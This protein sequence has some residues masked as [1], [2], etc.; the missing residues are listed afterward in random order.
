MGESAAAREQID[1]SLPGV[2]RTIG[3]RHLIRQTYEELERIFLSIGFT[4]VEAPDGTE[5]LAAFEKTPDEFGM[6][7]TDVMMPK[8]GG[9][10]LAMKV[11]ELRPDLPVVFMSGFL[12][13]PE[14]L[15]M[16]NDRRVR[17]LS[18]PFDIDALVTTIKSE[19]GGVEADV[20]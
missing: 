16:V 5:A 18:K 4:V 12:R 1:L 15:R 20:A 17:F 3:T 10:E 13:D 2:E 8:M 7:L 11:M 14:V 9:R 6:L 19:M